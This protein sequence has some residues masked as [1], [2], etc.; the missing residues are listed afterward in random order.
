MGGA[1]PPIVS[2]SSLIS[3][4]DEAGK[5]IVG[6]Q[7]LIGQQT[8]QPH[9][10]N[11]LITDSQGSIDTKDLDWWTGDEYVTVQAAGFVRTTLVAQKK[12]GLQLTLRKPPAG[13]TQLTGQ[14]TGYG[15]LSNNGVLDASLIYRSILKTE[16]ATL[17]PVRLL[18]S[19]VDVQT[20]K[21]Q[22]V[23]FPSNLSI[24][25]QTETIF[26]FVSVDMNKPIYRLFVDL[27]SQASA[28]L[29]GICA[30]TGFKK[31]IDDL[32]SGQSFLELINSLNF[33]SYSVRPIALSPNM[34]G[35]TFGLDFAIQENRLF[36]TQGVQAGVVPSGFAVVATALTPVGSEFLVTDVKKLLNGE[37]KL[38][39]VPQNSNSSWILKTLKKNDPQRTDFTGSDYETASAILMRPQEQI[40]LGFLP[41]VLP[42][43]TQGRSLNLPA[44]NIPLGL[45][46]DSVRITLS[47]LQTQNQG[48][49]KKVA[50]LALWDFFVAQPVAKVTLPILGN[51]PWEIK[52]A[53]R[54]DYSLAAKPVGAKELTHLTKSAIDFS[55]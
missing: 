5:P 9:I 40:A 33:K 22:E 36:L 44:V 49:V 24:P 7:V 17:D 11:L 43:T 32:K 29:V 38:L 41:A 35:K 14:T 52:G 10:G 50:K 37:S 45:Q 31:M 54:W 6:A 23:K 20:L 3:I 28:S 48:V 47:Q 16:L 27:A 15:Q 30:Q 8:G 34:S 19:E 26:L 13:R 25:S 53:F 21:G 2:S 1:L 55:Y 51:D 42:P 4:R 39:S 46:A 18:E 12:S